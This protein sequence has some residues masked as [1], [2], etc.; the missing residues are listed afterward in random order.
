MRANILWTQQNRSRIG[1]AV[2]PYQRRQEPLFGS[3]RN[4]K[5]QEILFERPSN[6]LKQLSDPA[7][8]RQRPT[9]VAFRNSR[10]C[11]LDLT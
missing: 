9:P 2:F 8:E 10:I 7:T 5:S 6:G 3:M 11:H 1:F 4:R